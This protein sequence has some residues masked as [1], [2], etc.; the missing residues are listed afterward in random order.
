MLWSKS[1]GN[2]REDDVLVEL[3]TLLPLLVR[4]DS[5][6]SIELAPIDAQCEELVV[7]VTLQL[8]GVH[9]ATIRVALIRRDQLRVPAGR[10][11]GADCLEVAEGAD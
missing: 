3:L 5:G 7:H 2:E 11:L 8:E 4:R 1:L 9:Q 10:E 6:Q